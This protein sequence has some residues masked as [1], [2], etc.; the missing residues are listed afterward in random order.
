MV[1]REA[2]PSEAAT[3]WASLSLSESDV[4]VAEVEE[5]V[6]VVMEEVLLLEFVGEADAAAEVEEWK[7]PVTV[8]AESVSVSVSLSVSLAV[9]ELSVSLAVEEA[10]EEAE[11]VSSVLLGA[12]LLS[13][14]ITKGGV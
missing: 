12:V 13:L 9:L 4:L 2:P 5:R 11:E 3:V 7:R 1:A 6:E 10:V 14:S 8:L